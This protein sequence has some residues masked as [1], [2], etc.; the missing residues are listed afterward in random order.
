[1]L[2][3]TAFKNVLSCKFRLITNVLPTNTRYIAAIGTLDRILYEFATP[4]T[5]ATHIIRIAQSNISK[6]MS[7]LLPPRYFINIPSITSIASPATAIVGSIGKNAIIINTPTCGRAST[8]LT[9]TTAA[10][11]KYHPGTMVNTPRRTPPAIAI[12]TAGIFF[13][14][15]FSDILS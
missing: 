5:M 9:P 1:M 11:A 7:L 6:L 13:T 14:S 4:Y 8:R 12:V 3:I 2:F 10:T 15:V